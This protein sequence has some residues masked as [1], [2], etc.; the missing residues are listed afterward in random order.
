MP[1]DF[2]HNGGGDDDFHNTEKM[3]NA[4]GVVVAGVAN[5]ATRYSVCDTCLAVNIA[6]RIF[7]VA[8]KS[9]DPEVRATLR[10]DLN[11]LLDHSAAMENDNGKP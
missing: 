11:D 3:L 9:E 5:V 6:I 4:M 10:S 8:L 1:L 2:T 7:T